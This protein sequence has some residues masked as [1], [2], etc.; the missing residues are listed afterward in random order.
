M[1]FIGNTVQTQGF[2]PAIDYFSGNASTVTFT[3]SRPVVSVSQMVV[4]VANVIQN[5]SSAYTVSGNSITF[6]SAPPSGTNNIWVEYTSLITTYNA[7]SQSPSVIGDITASGGYL[8]TGSFNNSFL[9]GTIVD[10]VTGNGR[11]T[12]GPSDGFTLYNGGTTGRTAL[13]SWDTSGNQTL[14]ASGIIKNSSGRPALNQN[15]GVLQV[16]N[17]ISQ[18]YVGTSSTS[19][20]TTNI[21]ASITP[22]STSSKILVLVEVN[23]IQRSGGLDGLLLAVYRNGSS[24]FSVEGIAGYCNNITSGEID[25][26]GVSQSYL[27]SPASVSS[28]T[29][30]I[31]IAAATGN[32]SLHINNYYGSVRS[33]ASITLMEIAG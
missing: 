21:S 12:V 10:Y 1:A 13:A 26:G 4:V 8:A 24:V 25:V 32:G 30:T 11:I 33:S 2:T 9:D 31:Y 7:I 23:G 3:L 19:F 22:S 18:S 27:D 5:P 14:S 15:G 16:V 20:I 6:S 17:T 29:Y 28:Q